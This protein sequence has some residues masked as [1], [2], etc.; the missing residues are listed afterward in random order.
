METCCVVLLR[1]TA[2]FKNKVIGFHVPNPGD[3]SRVQFLPRTGFVLSRAT[4]RQ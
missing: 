1:S 4:D 3:G 2:C